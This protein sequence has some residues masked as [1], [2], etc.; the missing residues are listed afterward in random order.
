M[1]VWGAK[2]DAGKAVSRFAS[3]RSVRISCAASS[4]EQHSSQFT[5]D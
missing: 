5:G 1:V 4:Y 2:P 3:P